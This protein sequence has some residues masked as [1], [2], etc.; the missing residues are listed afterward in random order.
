MLLGFGSAYPAPQEQTPNRRISQQ[1]KIKES[2]AVS[3]LA[4]LGVPMHRDPKGV[5]RWIEA[6]KGE[7]SDEAMAYLPSLSSLEW[8]EIGG[9]K[10]SASGAA[11]L[12]GCTALKRLY[13]HDINLAG[14][15]LSWLSS[16]KELEA[17][18]LQRTG[19]HGAFIKNLAAIGHSHCIE[20]ERKSY[21]GR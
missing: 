2:D 12:K 10:V 19:I 1:Q 13:L 17:L 21:L 9:G 4:R 5:V 16:L 11:H 7:F 3:A 20:F 14:D 6:T 15:E 18:S 8:L